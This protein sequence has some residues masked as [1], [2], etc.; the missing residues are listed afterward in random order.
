MKTITTILRD[1]HNELKLGFRSDFITGTVQENNI[2]EESI[3]MLVALV[4]PITAN[5]SYE[6][7]GRK[8]TY[9]SINML[10]VML[11]ELEATDEQHE[12]IIAKC[13]AVYNQFIFR[14]KKV[15]YITV[16]EGKIVQVYND[17]DANLTGLSATFQIVQN[18]TDS[19]CLL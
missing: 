10:F 12:D 3:E 8:F 5:P 16:T 4:K 13:L 19:L 15:E 6:N 1:V 9:L 14:L 18:V 2:N 17:Q 11:D 7:G